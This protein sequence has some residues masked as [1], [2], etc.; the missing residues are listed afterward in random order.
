MELNNE[1]IHLLYSANRWEKKSNMLETLNSG[2][3]II[4]DRYYHSGIAYTMAKGVDREWA[5]TADK[6]LIAPDLMIFLDVSREE[7]ERRKGFGEERFEVVEFQNKVRMAYDQLRNESWHVIS[8]DGKTPEE[9]TQDVLS[10]IK[11]N[12]NELQNSPIKYNL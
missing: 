5:V 12:I 8:V 9:V 4:L 1:V 2:V 10:I 6:G 11:S 3:N 7:A